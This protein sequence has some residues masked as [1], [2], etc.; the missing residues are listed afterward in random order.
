MWWP[1][2][3]IT[4]VYMYTRLLANDQGKLAQ[5]ILLKFNQ[6]AT[7]TSYQH[8]G[9]SNVSLFFDCNLLPYDWTK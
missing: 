4:L 5:Q 6:E 9:K 2:T 3:S 8:P 7:S 1:L